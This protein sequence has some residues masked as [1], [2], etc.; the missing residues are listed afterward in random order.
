V[1]PATLLLEHLLWAHW[2]DTQGFSGETKAHSAGGGILCNKSMETQL[3]WLHSLMVHLSAGA[4]GW[5]EMRVHN[6]NNNYNTSS[7][8]M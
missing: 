1:L 5:S 6:D 4:E 2:Y 3:G 8:F 7:H